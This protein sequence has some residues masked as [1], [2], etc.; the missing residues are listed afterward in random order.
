MIAPP[1]RPP[2]V[3]CDVRGMRAQ[4]HP[5]A[6]S[7]GA[8]SAVERVTDGGEVSLVTRVRRAVS[9]GGVFALTCVAVHMCVC[10]R[11]R[12][13]AA[14]ASIHALSDSI[15]QLIEESV[16]LGSRATWYTS[17]LG[18]KAD[19]RVLL[20]VLREH[21]GGRCMLWWW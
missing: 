3:E 15:A 14:P 9:G 2:R 6:A 10:E 13:R 19:V 20:R 7:A 16:A 17:L 1:P 4:G 11:E 21:G 8:I 5:N 12:E 18:R